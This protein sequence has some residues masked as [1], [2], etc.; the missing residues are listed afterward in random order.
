M[1]FYFHLINLALFVADLCD[2][3]YWSI[4]GFDSLENQ[5]CMLCSIG[6]YQDQLGGTECKKCQSGYTTVSTGSTSK[7]D[8][9]SKM[10]TSVDRNEYLY[11][12]KLL[13]L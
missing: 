4:D 10:L 12:I 8:C 9:G 11:C 1:F 5:Q 13:I 2:K 7:D 6:T 3:G